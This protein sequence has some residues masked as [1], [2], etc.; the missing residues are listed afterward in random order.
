MRGCQTEFGAENLSDDEF[1]SWWDSVVKHSISPTTKYF[2]YQI[3]KKHH[4]SSIDILYQFL[5]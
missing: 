2:M 5:R 1:L 4:K 3:D